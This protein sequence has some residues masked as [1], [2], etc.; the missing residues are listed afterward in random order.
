MDDCFMTKGGAQIGW[1]NA[2]WPLAQLSVTKEHLTLN[3]KILGS[4]AFAPEQ[5]FA[6]ERYAPIPLLARFTRGIRIRHCAPDNPLRI[7]F[8]SSRNPDDILRDIRAC[9]FIPV[10]PPSEVSTRKGIPARW[11]A[12]LGGVAVWN[13]LF[14]LPFVGN[15]P[16]PPVPNWLNVCAPILAA[17]GLSIVALRST[18]LQRLILKP[19]RSF[20]E[21]RP[22]FRLLAFITGLLSII[23]SALL[24]TGAFHR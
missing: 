4:Y 12:I 23:S 20:G 22:F 14:M 3:V 15:R 18:W 6:I 11:S 17:F 1:M 21:I 10:A 16:G 7:I 19:G 5:V 2:S 9:G 8:W 24:A 13:L